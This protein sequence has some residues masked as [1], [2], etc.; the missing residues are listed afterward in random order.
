MDPFN[1]III[2]LLLVKGEYASNN[3]VFQQTVGIPMGNNCAT[4]LADL[5]LTSYSAFAAKRKK[6]LFLISRSAIKTMSLIYSKF[7]D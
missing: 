6:N 2:D 7:V 5:K 4:L 1:V 3:Y